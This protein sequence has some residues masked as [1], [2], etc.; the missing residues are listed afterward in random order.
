MNYRLVCW[1][2]RGIVGLNW[3]AMALILAT[4]HVQKTLALSAFAVFRTCA[5][6]GFAYLIY[7]SSLVTQKHA[8]VAAWM[9][10]A[11]LVLPMFVFWFA[12][13]VA[14]F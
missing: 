1:T 6:C 2:A 12:V 9:A 11:L 4:P 14:T 8:R 10:D 5:V 3:L 7:E 13:R